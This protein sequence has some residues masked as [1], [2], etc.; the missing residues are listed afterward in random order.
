MTV[1]KGLRLFGARV[2]VMSGIA[3]PPRPASGGRFR[4]YGVAADATVRVTAPGTL[5]CRTEPFGS[6]LK[7]LTQNFLTGIA[8]GPR[9]HGSLGHLH[10]RD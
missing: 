2:E 4:L 1:N 8:S 10:A 3:R 5:P 6:P 9:P 7:R